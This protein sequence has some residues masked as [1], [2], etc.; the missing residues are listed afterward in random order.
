MTEHFGIETID[1]VTVVML[2]GPKVV[3]EIKDPLY[4]LVDGLRQR[5]LV[6]DFANVRFMSSSGL[7]ILITLKMKV[8]AAGGRL[9]LSGLDEDLVKLLRLTNL[10]GRFEVF[11]SRQEAVQASW[12]RGGEVGP[13]DL[14]AVP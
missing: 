8:D 1:G 12:N 7:A 5:R 11:G 6:L 4:A 9:R 14:T 2:T 13:T 10:L 3:V